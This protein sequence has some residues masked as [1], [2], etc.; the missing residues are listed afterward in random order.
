MLNKFS[1][2][3]NSTFDRSG[4]GRLSDLNHNEWIPI[5]GKLEKEQSTFN[6]LGAKFRSPEYKWPTD[7]LHKWSRIW[8][9]PYIYK[10]L[11]SFKSTDSDVRLHVVDLGSGVTFFPFAISK[12]N[13]RV[14]CSD[15]D[16]ICERDLGEASA[17]FKEILGE[18]DFRLIT[19]SD[20][21]FDSAEVDIVY[22]ISVL[23]HI[24]NFENTVSEVAR[25]LKPGGIFLLTIDLDLRG[26]AELGPE[27]HLRL[28]NAL[29]EHFEFL[30]PE[31]TIHP[32]DMLHSYTGPFAFT[33]SKPTFIWNYIKQR[34]IKPM[35][36]RK[37]GE[38]SPPKLAVQA[39]SL[40]LKMNR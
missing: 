2:Q 28:T 26:D 22:C 31:T 15:I 40:R 33:K 34:V 12:L 25:I 8:E 10:Q 17:K 19:D 29:K 5:I 38:L 16:P 35:L 39:Y 4:L 21:P 11:E 13:Y 23:E 32:A 20:L 14:T 9:Y 1:N 37:P 6:S 27:A 3:A 7:S 30:H 36:G 18:V 24:P